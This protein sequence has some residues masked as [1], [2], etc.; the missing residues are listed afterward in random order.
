MQKWKAVAT[1][2][3]GDGT[4]M[5]HAIGLPMKVSGHV[6]RKLVANYIA[7]NPESSLHDQTLRNWI[8]WEMNMTLEEYVKR[9]RAGQWGGSLETTLLAS[10]FRSVIFVYEPNG[11]TCKRIAES[12]PDANLPHL[13]IKGIPP[14]ICILYVGSHY[15]SLTISK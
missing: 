10:L 5:F 14:Y 9:L 1:D 13:N 6:L 11:K 4:C 7:D 3:P 8:T 2:V 15:M 12:R